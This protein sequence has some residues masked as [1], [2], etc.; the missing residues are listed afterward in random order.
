M[1]QELESAL[2]DCALR[3]RWPAW[4]W[5]PWLCARANTRGTWP[6]KEKSMAFPPALVCQRVRRAFASYSEGLRR[7]EGGAS[8][9][10]CSSACVPL[11]W[12]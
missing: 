10:V 12:T 2:L 6:A 5:Q 9:L 1:G 8:V 4:T 11:R 3:L 7:S